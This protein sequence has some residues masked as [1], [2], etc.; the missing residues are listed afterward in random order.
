M[1]ECE[2]R[3]FAQKDGPRAGKAHRQENWLR[4]VSDL[5]API[6]I[7]DREIFLTMSI[8]VSLDHRPLARAENV[9]EEAEQ[10]MNLAQQAGGDRIR[11]ARSIRSESLAA[12]LK[13]PTNEVGSTSMSN[14]AAAV[15][16]V[17]DPTAAALAAIQEALNIKDED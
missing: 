14:S 3:G 1:S 7:K 9:V 16:K 15:P 12:K 2:R 17:E 5:R 4:F 10:C 11:W 13:R 8:G 6:T